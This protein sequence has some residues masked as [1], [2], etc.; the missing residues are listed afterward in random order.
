MNTYLCADSL[1]QFR[2]SLKANG[3]SE[4]TAKAY[5]SDLKLFLMMTSRTTISEAEFEQAARDYLTSRRNEAATSTLR[6]I[7]TFRR[8]SRWAWGKDCLAGYKAPTPAE[9]EPHPIPG[10]IEAISRMLSECR[11]D[12]HRALVGLQGY[13]ALRVSEARGVLASQF[14][15]G[16]HQLHVRGK[17][18]KERRLDFALSTL[19]AV[20]PAYERSL[21]DGLPMCRLSDT[22]ARQAIKSIAYRAGF[23]REIA[24]HDLRAT[25]LTELYDRTKDIEL[26]RRFAGHASTKQTQVYIGSR[27][28]ALRG[29]IEFV[30]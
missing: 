11:S 22:G 1:E 21:R 17:G 23:G 19:A 13:F 3:L 28:E 9:P 15:M 25:C 7:A 5:Y 26:V 4:L 16:E 6:R 24:S 14:D 12:D 8:F 18:A 27:R 10:G 2:E 30:A 20:L 29:A